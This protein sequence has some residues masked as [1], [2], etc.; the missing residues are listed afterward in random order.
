[1]TKKS[2]ASQGDLDE[3]K[4]S[5][6]ELGS[7]AYAYTSEGDPNAGVIIGDESVLVI[8]PLATPKMAEK[9][10]R[11]IREITD[12]PIHHVV[13]THY[14]A[15]RIL[16]ASAF[17]AQQIIA[18]YPT[19]A[20]IEERGEED[21]KSEAAR[22]PRL[23][24]AIET[25]KGLTWPTLTFSDEI[26]LWLGKTQVCIRYLGKGHSKGD[27]IV[28]LPDSQIFFSGDLVECN[29]TP[30][31]GDAYLQQWPKTLDRLLALHPKKLVPG[32]GNAIQS[33]HEIE[34]HIKKTKGFVEDLLHF[35]K[36]G[37]DKE[38]NL[39]TVFKECYEEMKKKYG[40]WFIFDHC[41]P[42]NVSRAF[43]ELSGIEHPRIWNAERDKQLWETLYE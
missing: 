37:M 15:V 22:F 23:F 6:I 9:L 41:M 19:Y 21:F 2:F 40:H 30:Y 26:T 25:I 31:C 20:L 27:T 1:M 11:K 5:F 36:K 43:D 3:K 7:G 29:A 13:C 4:S 24:D 35:T 32:R 8:D 14:H 38:R 18:S 12:K 28:F 16:G 17:N 33:H 39:K 34:E 42:F 10:K